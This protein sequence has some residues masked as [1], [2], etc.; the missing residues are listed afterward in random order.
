MTKN[1]RIE[2]KCQEGKHAAAK[3]D[4]RPLYKIV[5]DLTGSRPNN[6]F[7]IKSKVATIL[8]S[9][10]EQNV[11]WVEKF[12]EVLNQPVPTILLDLDDHKNNVNDDAAIS[13]NDISK[14]E[15]ER[16]SRVL[17]NNKAACLDFIPAELLEWVGDAMV[18]EMTRITNI[19]WH[20]VK[21]PD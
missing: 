12:G 1:T 15:I 18:D 8:L 6:S 3:N 14:D 13:M 4:A 10:K 16:G 5:R 21:V 9:E 7:P 2:T 19:V 11:R 17:A 20:T